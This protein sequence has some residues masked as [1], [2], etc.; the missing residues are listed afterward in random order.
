MVKED[1]NKLSLKEQVEYVNTQLPSK[2]LTKVCGDLNIARSTLA[3]KFKKN[4]YQLNS[5][6]DKY[7]FVLG[8]NENTIEHKPIEVKKKTKDEEDIKDLLAIKDKIKSLIEWHENEQKRSKRQQ[9]DV[10]LDK[11]NGEAVSRTFVLYENILDKYVKF[12][13]A[14]RA[15]RRQDILSQALSEFLEKYE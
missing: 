8:D 10:E 3:S 9:F 11:F 2:T 1:F 5:N 13:E 6:Q 4:G 12:C 7:V 15:Y 14:H